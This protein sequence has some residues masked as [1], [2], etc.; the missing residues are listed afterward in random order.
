MKKTDTYPFRE[1]ATPT[2]KGAACWTSRTLLQTN[3]RTPYSSHTQL[4][5][6]P[7]TQLAV[8]HVCSAHSSELA[9]R[10]TAA[11]EC[12][13][14][15]MSCDRTHAKSSY[16]T[17]SLSRT[18]ELAR[19]RVAVAAAKRPAE[20]AVAADA[21]QRALPTL[22]TGSHA[23]HTKRGCRT[24]PFFSLRLRSKACC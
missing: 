5:L 21:V 14:H 23:P 15:R 3:I 22:L 16:N 11:P 12:A 6:C 8:D 17:V 10:R 4:A 19:P 18:R 2:L 7:S 13:R 24:Q 20:D 1:L 9:A